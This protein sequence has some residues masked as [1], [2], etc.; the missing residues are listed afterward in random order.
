MWIMTTI[1]SEYNL[2][3]FNLKT[4]HIPKHM[5][6]CFFILDFSYAPETPCCTQITSPYVLCGLRRARLVLVHVSCCG[7]I[8]CVRIIYLLSD[9]LYD[10]KLF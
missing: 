2:I 7:A 8:L 5:M 4:C 9:D 3:V 6:C 10:E 1:M